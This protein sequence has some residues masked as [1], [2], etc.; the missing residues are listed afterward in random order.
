MRHV[1]DVR[2]AGLV[3]ALELP[4]HRGVAAVPLLQTEKKLGTPHDA[5][6]P[7]V[8]DQAASACSASMSKVVTCCRRRVC[9]GERSTTITIRNPTATR[10]AAPQLPQCYPHVKR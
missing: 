1:P 4:H 8:F 2:R 7:P 5:A 6:S 9:A 3:P 10:T